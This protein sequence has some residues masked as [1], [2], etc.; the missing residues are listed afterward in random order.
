M[1][2]SIETLNTHKELGSLSQGELQQI[3]GGQTYLTTKW[4]DWFGNR[5]KGKIG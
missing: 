4:S 2:K 1:L 3:S 5:L